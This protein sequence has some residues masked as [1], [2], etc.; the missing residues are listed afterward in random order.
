MDFLRKFFGSKLKN[1][2]AD[3]K[4]E[5]SE[6]RQDAAR[7]LGKLGNN[8]AM[9]A[10]LDALGDEDRGTQACAAQALGNIGGERALEALR[11]IVAN[12]GAGGWD[13]ALLAL[14]KHRDK[15]AL[16]P[17]V[18]VLSDRRHEW[19][20]RMIA[21][22]ALGDLGDREAIGPLKDA[23]ADSN[24]SVRAQAATSLEKLSR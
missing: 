11:R 12:E 6:L 7:R 13:M 2:L 5:D 14:A 10:L 16:A 19:Y 22:R 20:I 17:A 8:E 18:R 21:A 3:L 4:S 15:T 24:A 23:A 1:A 9:E